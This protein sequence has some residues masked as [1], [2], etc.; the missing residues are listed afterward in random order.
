MAL[1]KFVPLQAAQGMFGIPPGQVVGFV[2]RDS[3]E[4]TDVESSGSSA[5]CRLVT[6]PLVHSRVDWNKT[7]K[8][9]LSGGTGGKTG[10][11]VYRVGQGIKVESSAP[12][13][14]NSNYYYMEYLFQGDATSSSHT[15][16]WLTNSDGNQILSFTFETPVNVAMVRVC[17]IVFK[18]PDLRSNYQITVVNRIGETRNVTGGFID[19]SRD[20]LGLFHSHTVQEEGVVE[21]LF[22]LTREGAYG[23]CLKKIEIWSAE[24][25]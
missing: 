6:Q 14:N 10:E 2:Y 7:T 20:I 22:E 15:D 19:T 25:Q 12:V 8:M 17:P 13:Y 21:I 18:G 24:S 1:A 5:S 4:G 9:K 23:V 16:Y 3:A 11:H